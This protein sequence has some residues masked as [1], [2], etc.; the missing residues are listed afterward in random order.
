MIDASAAGAAAVQSGADAGL[1]AAASVVDAAVS[2][3]GAIGDLLAQMRQA[4]IG[5]SDPSLGADARGALNTSFQSDL[6][7]ITA[8][9]GQ[10][11]SGGVNL[12]DG[13]VAG[14]LQLPAGGGSTV[15]LTGAN[16]PL[17]GPL[18]GLGADASLGD[19]A[20]AAPAAGAL[21]TAIGAVG[22]AV[23]QISAQ[24]QAIDSH[25]SVLT[26]AGLS[27]SPGVAGPGRSQPR[28]GRRPPP[29]A[30]GAAAV[31]GR[32]GR[33]DQPGPAVDPG[34]FPIVEFRPALT[35]W[36]PRARHNPC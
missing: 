19:P 12:I 31:A 3:G 16:L 8:A 32:R 25:L 24:G 7:K 10:A 20:S 27:A 33:G 22:Q 17:G 18:I 34:S 28:P 2:A 11:S 30:A 1:G 4:A 23:R 36:Q 13:S 26:Q 9:V 14:S 21:E 5:A 29:S 35:A 15:T 6:A